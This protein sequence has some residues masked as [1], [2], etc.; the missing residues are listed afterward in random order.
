MLVIAWKMLFLLSACSHS[1][2]CS[3]WGWVAL[4]SSTNLHFKGIW[5][6]FAWRG[7]YSRML[8][9]FCDNSGSSGV[10]LKFS[11][12]QIQ[13]AASSSFHFNVTGLVLENRAKIC[14]AKAI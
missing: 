11:G 5:K 3:P 10:N 4:A 2:C 1:S 8:S 12:T 9:L 13:F 14:Y 6:V 7:N